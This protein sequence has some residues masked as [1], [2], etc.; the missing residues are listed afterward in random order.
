MPG[1]DAYILRH[2]TFLLICIQALTQFIAPTELKYLWVTPIQISSLVGHSENIRNSTTHSDDNPFTLTSSFINDLADLQ[3]FHFQDFCEDIAMTTSY[4]TKYDL[5]EDA[6]LSDVFYFYQL[7]VFDLLMAD[8]CSHSI[9]K[10]QQSKFKEMKKMYMKI[11]EVFGSAIE[12]YFVSNGLPN[13]NFDS[14]K[15]S[16]WSSIHLN[17]TFHQAHHHDGNML[18]GILYLRVPP[19]S[20]GKL[21]FEDPRG[22]LPPFGRTH[23]IAPAVGDLILFPSWLVHRVE[24]TYSNSPRISLSFNYGGEMALTGDISRG[25]R[26]L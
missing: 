5:H 16:L 4:R 11:L 7:E 22:S 10:T 17:G 1:D 26:T 13:I 23:R 6:S 20:S 9:C 19:L 21:V 14:R 18:S 8:V 15:V 12:H 25:L 24:P 3:W 2:V